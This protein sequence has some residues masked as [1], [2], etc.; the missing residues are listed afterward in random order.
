M[1]TRFKDVYMIKESYKEKINSFGIRDPY[2]RNFILRYE[3]RLNWAE[4]KKEKKAGG[5]PTDI[6]QR[7]IKKLFDGFIESKKD[8]NSK[9]S[10]YSTT[11]DIDWKR[12]I[13][14][15]K[16]EVEN[17]NIEAESALQ[18][19][20]D[21]PKGAKETILKDIN[22]GKQK[23]FDEWVEYLQYNDRYR[24][25]YAFMYVVAKP[26]LDREGSK[27]NPPT[28]INASIV[29]QLFEK[30]KSSESVPFNVTKLYKSY[31]N[32]YMESKNE[33]VSGVGGDWM[34]IPSQSEDPDKF[35]ENITDLMNMSYDSW[36]VRQD[37]FARNYLAD[38]AFWLYYIEGKDGIKFAQIA[39]RLKGDNIAE[40]RGATRNQEVPDEFQPVIVDFIQKKEI[41][42]G[43]K[44]INDYYR[45]KNDDEYKEKIASNLT[46]L[47]TYY[48]E[49]MP[50]QYINE[51]YVDDIDEL[52]NV[53]RLYNWYKGN[54]EEIDTNQLQLG[55]D[56]NASFE[57][58]DDTF[59]FNSLLVGLLHHGNFD[60]IGFKSGG[61]AHVEK[62]GFNYYIV[63]QTTLHDI[64]EYVN[65]NTISEFLSLS[66]GGYEVSWANYEDK[67]IYINKIQ[68]WNPKVY[69]KLVKAVEIEQGYEI[70]EVDVQD[71]EIFDFINEKMPDNYMFRD[72]ENAGWDV[73]YTDQLHNAVNDGVKDGLDGFTLEYDNLYAYDED[74][75]GEIQITINHKDLIDML[76]GDDGLWEGVKDG[77]DEIIDWSDWNNVKGVYSEFN[78]EAAIDRFGQE[79]DVGDVE[80]ECDEV[81]DE[82]NKRMEVVN[83]IK[84][85]NI[86]YD[87]L[88]S[89]LD[90]TGHFKHKNKWYNVAQVVETRGVIV[91]EYL[92]DIEDLN[93]AI[94]DWNN[95]TNDMNN[96]FIFQF[97]F[98]GSDDYIFI[99]QYDKV[100]SD[101]MNA[102]GL[103]N[104][105]QTTYESIYLEQLT[106]F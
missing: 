44:F 89:T 9:K 42:G 81:I 5:K 84:T 103:R 82:Y 86:S 85:I 90:L 57:T 20:K 59:K 48:E 49:N 35:E 24:G 67:S 80:G 2:I 23:I 58:V 18:V 25:N 11:N 36:C 32:D 97:A 45:K 30:I 15:L 91:P 73:G 87:E 79:F 16:V 76:L 66:D 95:S 12:E 28:P 33:I 22:E 37:S 105:I 8:P 54:E 94:V 50:I 43:D 19:F 55:L 78:K 100:A 17:G 61:V 72:A 13:D 63:A 56:D 1:I 27:R 60:G 70:G 102:A 41:K 106:E 68:E 92:Y 6:I 21:N 88:I 99:A 10:L 96:I 101:K 52:P 71:D 31:Y 62:L 39:I 69:S 26:I 3:N 40:I 38:G 7:H 104:D 53:G 93:Q 75:A 14:I 65:D 46:E 77:S 74:N 51:D 64:S 34:K 98:N 29:A 4:L 47:L 83:S